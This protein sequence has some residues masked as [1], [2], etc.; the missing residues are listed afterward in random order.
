MIFLTVFHFE[1]LALSQCH[2]FTISHFQMFTNSQFNIV[3]FLYFVIFTFSHYVDFTFHHFTLSYFCVFSNFSILS[4]PFLHT[5][6]YWSYVPINPNP[7]G[8]L[9]YGPSAHTRAT[10]N[11]TAAMCAHKHV[12]KISSGPS[13]HK[14]GEF[15]H[16]CAYFGHFGPV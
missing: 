1:I 15:W 4:Y 11:Q 8:G 10:R 9:G 13:A 16:F 3:P 2:I 6:I 7:C 5:R 14:N 12:E